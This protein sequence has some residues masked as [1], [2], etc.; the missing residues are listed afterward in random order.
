MV[1]LRGMDMRSSWMSGR[2]AI[3]FGLLGTMAAGGCMVQYEN[4]C[5]RAHSCPTGSGGAGGI[6]TSSS[7][8][9]GGGV[10]P[11]CAGLPTAENTTDTCGVFVQADAMS[12]IEDGTQE[13]P[14]KTLQKALANAGGR[15]VYA[16]AS[17]PYA[18]AVTI[19]VP[20]E[21]YGGFDCAKGWRWKA[22]AKSAL[23]GP[24]GSVALTITKQAE[25]AKVQGFA[26]TAPSATKRG[27]SSIAVAVD[28]V[29]ATLSS[30]DI[31]AGDGMLGE[32]G[33]QP[34]VA[35][36]TP[37]ANAPPPDMSS[38]N[39]CINPAALVGGPAGLTTCAGGMT[40]GGMGG[41]GADPDLKLKAG[42]TG[43]NG[44]PSDDGSGLG[45]VGESTMKCGVGAS[46]KDGNDGAP[47]E[48]ETVLGALS[49]AGISV[50]SASDGKPGTP[51]SGGG[52]GGGSA[53]GGA[54]CPGGV[55][56][57]GASGGGGGGGG[58]GGLGGK[59]GK[60]GGSSIAIVSLGVKLALT[61]VSLKTG[62]G[63]KGGDGVLGQ[64]G[65]SAGAGAF[66]GAASGLIKAGCKGGDGGVG[67]G[68][69][70][71]GGGHGGHSVG[72]AY[73]TAPSVAPKLEGFTGKS[74]GSGG[75]SI[76][77]VLKSQGVKGSA[78]V[79]WSFDK[80]AACSK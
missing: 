19:A 23:N 73:V 70:L 9:D 42:G 28:D 59:G 30:C 8:E 48:G 4:E 13:N 68:G 41:K 61:A 34:P 33:A 71:G 45:G 53:S 67:G 40:N 14:Y 79:C 15:H 10:P 52:G 55:I 80:N 1:A 64:T 60:S 76:A 24:V 26:I 29:T 43:A 35:T 12:A 65:G 66:G 69:G 38:M 37:G 3:G 57:N 36:A 63:G 5:E 21:M 78:G 16:C 74:A 51:G 22:D 47:G 7:G 54:M 46:G 62:Y 20:V 6:P 39:A 56:G 2:L 32:G 31:T 25:G 44:M 11:S 75:F 17:A 49:L 77:N 27:G 50:T 72:I 58:C 18:E